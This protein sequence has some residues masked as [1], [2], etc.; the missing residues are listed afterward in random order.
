[1]ERVQVRSLR[2]GERARFLNFL[3]VGAGLNFVGAG[4]ERAK[5]FN[6]RRTLKDTEMRFFL[7]QN[8]STADDS[9]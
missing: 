3:R 7:I 5:Y 2:R 4:R 9:S 6:P 8:N 1:V